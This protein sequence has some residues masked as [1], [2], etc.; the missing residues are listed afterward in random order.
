M[1]ALFSELPHIS[2]K[3]S[4]LSDGQAYRAMVSIKVKINEGKE[5]LKNVR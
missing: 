2:G 1:S 4:N 3:I 5:Y